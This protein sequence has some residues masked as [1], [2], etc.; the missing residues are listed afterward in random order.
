MGMGVGAPGFEEAPL[1]PSLPKVDMLL[2]ML[3]TTCSGGISIDGSM[4]GAEG[5]LKRKQ[6]FCPGGRGSFRLLE[7]GQ[8]Q[9]GRG[10]IA[11]HWYSN[12]RGRG[13]ER[14]ANVLK[15]QTTFF[16]EQGEMSS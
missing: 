3:R 5:E 2:L 16:R 8:L 10:N 6:G 12:W 7:A 1:E 15:K 11:R 9:G 13:E 14:Q 4:T